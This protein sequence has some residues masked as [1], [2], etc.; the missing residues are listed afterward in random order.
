MSFVDFVENAGAA[1]GLLLAFCAVI[2]LAAK[3]VVL[4]WLEDRFAPLKAQ[5]EETHHQVATNGHV[6]ETPTLKD[7][8][9][10]LQNEV[11]EL[12]G[13][14]RS[15]LSS[16][17]S[18]MHVMGVIYDRHL[19]WSAR[20]SGKLWTALHAITHDGNP[21]TDE[22]NEDERERDAGPAGPAGD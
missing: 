8:V 10:T 13:E 11:R 1:L 7:A 19:D 6:S 18:D 22:R 4:P 20:E 3:Y 16:L 12:K 5:L 21:A 15:D 17:R 9:H 14:T 2:G